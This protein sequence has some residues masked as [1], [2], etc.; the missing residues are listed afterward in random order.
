MSPA[1]ETAA[2]HVADKA[3]VEIYEFLGKHV[4]DAPTKASSV[5]RPRP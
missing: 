5:R 2:E 4:E 3:W 1:R